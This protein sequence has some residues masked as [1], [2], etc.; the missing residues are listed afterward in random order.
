MGTCED[1]TAARSGPIVV[2]WQ[3]AGQLL[4]GNV[5]AKGHWL[6]V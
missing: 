2:V 3:Q 6:W 4:A 5:A 1:R